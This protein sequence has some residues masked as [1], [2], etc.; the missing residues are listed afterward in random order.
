MLHRYGARNFTSFKEGFEVSFAL[1]ANCPESI[2]KNRD[3]SNLLCVKGANASGKTNLLKALS[4]LSDFCA[5]SFSWKPDAGLYFHQ[6]FDK[7]EPSEF[8]IDFSIGDETYYYELVADDQVVHSESLSQ[9]GSKKGARK[10]RIFTRKG[11]KITSASNNNKFLKKIT[12]RDNASTISTAYQYEPKKFQGLYLFFKSIFSNVSMFGL[13]EG[14]RPCDFVSKYLKNNE[15][16]FDFVKGILKRV[17]P[18]LA[19]IEI[20]TRDDGE[21]ET[22]FFPIF[23][24]KTTDGIKPLTIHSISSGTESLYLQLAEYKI[25]L[26]L[27]G[28]LVLDEFDTYLH[29]HILPLLIDLFENDDINKKNGQLIFSTHNSEILNKMSKYRSILV[30]KEE[31]ESYAY[32][33]DDISGEILRNDRPISTIYD[34]GKIGGV[35][36]L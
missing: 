16:T 35:P 29:P 31:C 4:L 22:I 19:D 15:E 8:F 10:S 30:N 25:I 9:K 3:Y 24:F 11:N 13:R 18:D 23:R 36:P 28:V 27:A 5:D 33:L 21:Q 17:D 14:K 26:E 12:L 20:L 1:N 7:K 6:F 32:R 34:D 2:S